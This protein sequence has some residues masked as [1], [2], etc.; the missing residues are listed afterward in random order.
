VALPEDVDW[1]PIVSMR[2]VGELKVSRMES[3]YPV[4]SLIP[5]AMQI[6]QRMANESEMGVRTALYLEQLVR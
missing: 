1:R 3:P 6:K 4:D 2:E 5:I